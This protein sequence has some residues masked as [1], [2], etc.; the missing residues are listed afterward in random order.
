MHTHTKKTTQRHHH[1]K[2]K[3]KAALPGQTHFRSILTDEF[4]RVRG[5][6]GAIYAFGDAATIEQPKALDYADELFRRADTDG[7][8]RLSL[9]ELRE[10]L[11]TGAVVWLRVVCVWGG[12]VA[13]V[14]VA[15]VVVACG[16]ERVCLNELVFAS[17]RGS[18]LC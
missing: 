7:N 5:G 18:A 6:G 9:R 17:T 8:G 4:M 3:T 13:S 10:M 1:K 15:A 12:G 14:G 11:K 2:N 16:C